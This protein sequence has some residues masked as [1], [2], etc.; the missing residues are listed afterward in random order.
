MNARLNPSPIATLNRR[1][2]RGIC[3]D[4][5]LSNKMVGLLLLLLWLPATSLCLIERTG[6]LGHDDCC[7]SS[8]KAPSEQPANKTPCCELASATYKPTSYEQRAGRLVPPLVA[9]LT[10][11]P[12]QVSAAGPPPFFETSYPASFLARSQFSLRTALPPRAPPF[13]S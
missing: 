8:T 10:F 6:W 4:V 1:R 12:P 13:T 7:P 11:A 5:R 2:V 9:D 3:S